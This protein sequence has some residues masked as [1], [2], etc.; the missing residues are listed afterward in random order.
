MGNEYNFFKIVFEVLNKTIPVSRTLTK[1]VLMRQ[2]KMLHVKMPEFV[3][4]LKQSKIST[5][6]ELLKI[7]K[8]SPEVEVQK[9]EMVPIKENGIFC[10]ICKNC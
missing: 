2:H 7:L 5:K 8:E 6:K 10:I 4:N 1:Q 9:E 3:R